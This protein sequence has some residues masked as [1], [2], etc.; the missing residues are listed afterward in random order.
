MSTYFV[1]GAGPSG[2]GC[3]R[4][5]ATQTDAH[6]VLIDR[7]PVTGGESGW[8]SEEI[9]QLTADATAAGVELILGATATRWADGRL[10]LVSPL[11]IR[12]MNGD[13][14]FFAGGRRPSTAADLGFTGQRPAGVLPATVAEHLLASGVAIWRNP[15]IV[16][17]DVWAAHLAEE[18][19]RYGGTVSGIGPSD[20]ADHSYEP[21]ELEVIGV[22]RVE[23]VQ[24][25]RD[26]GTETIACDAVLLAADAR[27]N[28][29]IEGALSDTSDAV[30]FVQ[31]L[32]GEGVSRR[33][34]AGAATAENWI[35]ANGEASS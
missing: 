27:P 3:A 31:P 29:N 4:A 33:A 22:R 8:D 12:W 30:T 24:V 6:V 21:G 15:L 35:H 26:S 14:L 7:I 20:W 2:L 13:R 10:L 9:A 18:V 19:H 11:G 1:V 25:H 5:L 32:T 17:D 23:S 34:R 28:R 16:G